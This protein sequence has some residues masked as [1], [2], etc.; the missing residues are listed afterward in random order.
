MQFSTLLA[1]ASVLVSAVSASPISNFVTLTLESENDELNNKGLYSIHEGAAI[2]YVFVGDEPTTLN[3]NTT[4]GDI[5]QTFQNAD[6]QSFNQYL[7]VLGYGFPGLEV[8]VGSP[9]TTWTFV[10]GYLRGNGS[11]NFYVAKNTSDPYRV[12]VNSYQL[13]LFPEGF[14]ASAFVDV[15]PV[16]VKV[17][18]SATA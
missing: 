8:S 11:N 15:H 17:A 4:S 12:S 13:G 14:D 9:E 3:L 6:G 18:Q 2:N 5:Y 1:A 10:D 16:K 7:Q